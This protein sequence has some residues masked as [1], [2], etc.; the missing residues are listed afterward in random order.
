MPAGCGALP[1]AS[2]RN[3]SEQCVAW[4]CFDGSRATVASAEK[5]LLAQQHSRSRKIWWS[6]SFCQSEVEKDGKYL[7]QC[8]RRAG[9]LSFVRNKCGLGVGCFPSGPVVVHTRGGKGH[10]GKHQSAQEKNS[11]NK[12]QRKNKHNEE[13]NKPAE[14][15]AASLPT[16]TPFSSSHPPPPHPPAPAH[17]RL[18]LFWN[19]LVIWPC[20]SVC[21]SSRAA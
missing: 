18:T 10:A 2:T 4:L 12:F 16:S 19:R 6:H 3:A 1:R 5:E 8:P 9:R 15:H 13:R 20:R 21:T 7:G 11:N 14:P 17:T